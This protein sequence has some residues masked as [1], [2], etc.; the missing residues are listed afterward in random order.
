MLIDKLSSSPIIGIDIN[1]R[2]FSYAVMNNGDIVERGIIEPQDLIK[3]VKR[4]RPGAI[5]IDNIGEIMELSPSVIKRL[6]R[7]PFN[8][9]L[10]QVTRIKP[11][12]E[13]SLESLVN[14]YFGLNVS[15][16]DPDSTAEYLTRLCA[17]GVGSLVKVYEPETRIVVK[18]AISTTPGGMSR[19]RFERNVAHRI[20]QLTKEIKERLEGNG[21]DY[22][23]F[24]AQESEGLRSVV[25]I[26]Y[27]DRATVRSVVKPKKSMDIKVII[28]SV[29]SDSIKFVSLT[30]NEEVEAVR[31]AKDRR[32]IVGIDPGIVTGLAIL[33]L[34]GNV[35]RLHSGKNLSRRHVLRIIYQY[36]TP[37]LIAVDTAKPSDY[38]R[39]LAAMINAALY[40]P[41]R[42]LS[43]SEKSEIAIKVS[44]EQG[45][46]I[47]D[48]HMR[49]ALAAAYKSF[50][51]LKPKLDRV[52]EEVRRALMKTV[53]DVKT[54]VIKGMPIKQAIDE[55]G[56][57]IDVQPPQEVRVIQQGRGCDCKCEDIRRNYEE[58]IKALNSE[59]ERLTRLYNE[60][61]SRVEEL[62]NSYDSEARRDNLVRSLSIRL[63]IFENDLEKYKRKITELESALSDFMRSF[64]D[65]IG[66][67]NYALIKHNGNMSIDLIAQ[68]RN[69]IPVMTLGELMDIGIDRLINV[70]I[71]SV[72]LID[73]SD[74]NVIRPLWKRGLRVIPLNLVYNGPPDNVM[75]IDKSI[76][77]NTIES[78]GKEFL[79]A[80]DEDYLRRIVNE[81]RRLRNN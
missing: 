64:M 24:I 34:N 77:N 55:V 49:D 81:Y 37:V 54:L 18:A 61:K 66:G 56:R 43:V 50:I 76:I 25:F 26:A 6:G 44:K 42:D 68:A 63:E 74:K 58:T 46:T 1:G 65:Y 39:K 60:A 19:N 59:I 73:I 30:E 12:M 38:A 75:F 21:I 20:R 53:D 45:I 71:S 8:V 70:G 22:D 5:A 40:Y 36:G 10:I 31:A 4:V 3:L 80:V 9:H 47:K 7:L 51:Q 14:K 41:E 15:K 57:K 35:L 72:I 28:E 11:D 67:N 13:E 48:P 17:M 69:I 16:L 29:P 52:E 79:S 78:L 33:D 32:L 62:L 27:A 2:R 23:M